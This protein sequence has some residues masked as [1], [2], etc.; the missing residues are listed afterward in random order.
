MSIQP[1]FGFVL[2]YVAD[3]DSARDFYVNNIGLTVERAAPVFVQFNNHLAIAT[4][5]S[6]SGTREPEMYWLVS[7]AEAAYAE[8]SPKVEIVHPLEKKVF[9]KVFGIKDPAGQTLFILEFT[10]DRPSQP[11][12]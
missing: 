1:E 9:G 5:E 3:I 11:V 6:L 2:E 8:L 12:N 4:D 10:P 7:D